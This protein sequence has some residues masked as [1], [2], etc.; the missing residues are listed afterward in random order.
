MSALVLA[1]PARG[2]GGR[3]LTGTG[4]VTLLR[5]GGG[6]GFGA[7][8]LLYT[9]HPIP[10]GGVE[11]IVAATRPEDTNPAWGLHH[12]QRYGPQ[13][14]ETRPLM[15]WAAALEADQR[16]SES[17]ATYQQRLAGALVRIGRNARIIAPPAL[18]DLPLATW[19][20]TTDQ[21]V[22]F[23]DRHLGHTTARIGRLSTLAA[24]EE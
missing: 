1:F 23:P 20:M 14:S 17:Q 16:K 5:T 8:A 22:H 15:R 10:G 12:P 7:Y 18:V 19:E 13:T 24:K 4:R 9:T 6:A 11:A 3:P 2:D 21:L